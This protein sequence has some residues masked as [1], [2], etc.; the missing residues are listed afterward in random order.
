MNVAIFGLR[1]GCGKI[2]VTRFLEDSR[3]CYA[4]CYIQNENPILRYSLIY[5]ILE[6]NGI[7]LSKIK[8]LKDQK[9]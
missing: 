8:I 7:W 1:Y 3:E 2:A 6:N 5:N 9:Y 4:T